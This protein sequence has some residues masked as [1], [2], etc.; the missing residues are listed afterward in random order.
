MRSAAATSAASDGRRR[1]SRPGP[2]SPRL[3][4]S[5]R[6]AALSPIV[7][8]A[9]GRR[10]D[11]GQSGGDDPFGERGVLGEEPETGMD[12][13]GAGGKCRLDDG[14][15]VEEVEGIG[16]V[17]RRDDGADAEI[18][19]GAADAGRDLAAIGD[20]HGLDRGAAGRS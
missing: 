4:A 10:T 5:R 16:A 6:A 9:A 11:P 12:R 2:G 15:D 13:V 1:R 18:V 17:R 20:E 19:G 7:R 8:I 3:A 14:V